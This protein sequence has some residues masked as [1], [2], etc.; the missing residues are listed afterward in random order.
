IWC[1]YEE[2]VVEALAIW[3]GKILATGSSAEMLELQGAHTKLV[4]LH[5][6]FATP[7]LNDAH[8]H[9]ISTGLTL[10]WIDATP[11]KLPTLEALL[12]AIG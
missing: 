10:Q 1:G 3:Q 12:D 7:G 4:D 2:G 11:A 6:A 5:G 9:L 8:L